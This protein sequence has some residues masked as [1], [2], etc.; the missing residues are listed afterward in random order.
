[1]GVKGLKTFLSGDKQRNRPAGLPNGATK[2]NIP[3]EIEQWKKCVKL[4]K[5]LPF[6]FA[7][8][9]FFALAELMQINQP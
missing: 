4:P 7:I 1:M 3:R 5:A 8:F 2:I 9:L 6:K